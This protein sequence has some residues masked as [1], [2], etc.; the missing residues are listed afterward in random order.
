MHVPINSVLVT[1]L[2]ETLIFLHAVPYEESQNPDYKVVVVFPNIPLASVAAKV[3][4]LS[5]DI[6]PAL[7]E[8]ATLASSYTIFSVCRRGVL[9]RSGCPA[10]VEGMTL[11]ILVGCPEWG[12][13]AGG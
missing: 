12:A 6:G 4:R 7:E 10:P 13:V 9:F 5:G 11:L 8:P 1:P 3:F 2:S